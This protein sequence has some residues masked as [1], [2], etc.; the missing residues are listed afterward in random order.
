MHNSDI[1]TFLR[2]KHVDVKFKRFKWLVAEEIRINGHG[3]LRRVFHGRIFPQKLKKSVLKIL[4]F[5]NKE[6]L[7]GSNCYVVIA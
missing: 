2:I 6:A 4:K 5:I 3:E 1:R 7:R